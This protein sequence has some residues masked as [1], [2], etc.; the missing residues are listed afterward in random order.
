ML[1]RSDLIVQQSWTACGPSSC[2]LI[3]LPCGHSHFSGTHMHAKYDVAIS[4][5]LNGIQCAIGLPLLHTPSSSLSRLLQLSLTPGSPWI[6]VTGNASCG[7]IEV[8][9]RCNGTGRM[10]LRGGMY[11]GQEQAWVDVASYRCVSCDSAVARWMPPAEAFSGLQNES[12]VADKGAPNANHSS[13]AQFPPNSNN[14]IVFGS[15]T[16]VDDDSEFSSDTCVPLAACLAAGQTASG[17]LLAIATACADEDCHRYLL[18]TASNARLQFANHIFSFASIQRIVLERHAG[19]LQLYMRS[20]PALKLKLPLS[21]CAFAQYLL[22]ELQQHMVLFDDIA[23]AAL[24]NSCIAR[25]SLV[26]HGD[27]VCA[28]TVDASLAH[29]MAAAWHEHI[30]HLQVV[31]GFHVSEEDAEAT[32]LKL[33]MQART[34]LCADGM[35]CDITCLSCDGAFIAATPSRIVIA[36]LP[37]DRP[38]HAH[39]LSRVL[40]VDTLADGVVRLFFVQDG[41]PDVAEPY[42]SLER[43]HVFLLF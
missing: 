43:C 31:S 10:W 23:T 38:V 41:L 24:N 3:E 29:H 19:E 7:G 13:A 35:H 25:V 34:S 21:S 4:C 37:H 26:L 17:M 15:T 14:G 11:T 12:K 16:A 42:V 36:K 20:G 32:Q 9:L 22:L 1:F 2:P 27:S 5:E 33:Q 28:R 30:L 8:Q 18:V 6:Q 39:L 40:T